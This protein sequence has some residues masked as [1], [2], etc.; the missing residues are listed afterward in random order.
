[1]PARNQA[2]LPHSG[3]TTPAA[4]SPAG[5]ADRLYHG[6]LT[7]RRDV[8]YILTDTT[9]AGNAAP[10][11]LNLSNKLMYAGVGKGARAVT[12][13]KDTTLTFAGG[14]VDFKSSRQVVPGAAPNAFPPKTANPGAV[15]DAD[16]S[17]LV[18]VTDAGDAIYNAPMVVFGVSADGHEKS[19]LQDLVPRSPG[20]SRRTA[21]R[22][23]MARA[24]APDNRTPSVESCITCAPRSA[25]RR[26][27]MAVR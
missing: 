3:R 24:R 27:A 10:L 8:W 11:G 14:A 16:H 21:L 6:H 18:R 17:P 13:E 7:D 9:D 1:M 23:T 12:L 25:G 5:S 2:R 4:A 15:G 22:A 26:T 19:R 20:T